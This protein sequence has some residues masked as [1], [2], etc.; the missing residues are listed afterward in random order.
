MIPRTVLR[1]IAQQRMV[2]FHWLPVAMAC[3]VAIFF[4]QRLVGVI[5]A[6]C[7]RGAGRGRLSGHNWL[8]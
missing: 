7:C 2:L 4:S 5:R 6:V 3:G 1:D 8:A